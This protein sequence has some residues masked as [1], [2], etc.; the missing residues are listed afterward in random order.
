MDMEQPVRPLDLEKMKRLIETSRFEREASVWIKNGKVLNVYTGELVQANVVISDDRIAYVGDKEPMTGAET[1]IIDAG[2]QVL[3][4]GYIE[5]HAHPYQIYNFRTLGE[6]ALTRGTTTLVIDNLSFYLLLDRE[7]LLELVRESQ[8]FPVKYFWWMSLDPHNSLPEMMKKYTPDQLEP[9]L[10]ERAFIQGGELTSWPLLL[11]GVEP[12]LSSVHLMRSRGKRIEGHLPGASA[13]TLN[14]AAAGGVTACHES[15]TSE[16]VLRRLRLGYYATLRHSSIRPDVPHLVK[17]LVEAGMASSS[18]LMLTTD[19]TTPP[20]LDKGF[21]DHAL[22]LAMEAGMEPIDAYRMATLNIATYY[23]LDHELGGIAPGR[24][25]D[26]CFLEDVRNP[27]PLKVMSDGRVTVENGRRL[28]SFPEVDWTFLNGEEGSGTEKRRWEAR[29]DW[30]V[31]R[32]SPE[33][34]AVSGETVRCEFPVMKMLNAVITK[35]EDRSFEV[36]DER[37]VLS[38]QDREQGY[39]YLSLLDLEGRWVSNG[40]VKGFV[41]Q[42]EALCSTFSAFPGY[43]VAGWNPKSMAEAVN[44]ARSHGGG[45][46]MMEKGEVLYELPL[47]LTHMMSPLPMEKLIP[48]TQEFV[49]LMKERGYVHEDPLYSLLF[50]VALHLPDLRLSHQGLFSVKRGRVLWPARRLD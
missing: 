29:A 26:I 31:P 35:Q 20:F 1:E 16:E 25:A 45:I 33:A 37:V 9:L 5:P 21:T 47:P 10:E 17:G 23:G 8:R 30:F 2:G 40:I 22:R 7:R 39:L 34:A 32:V 48:K 4:P 13:E 49:G 43:V 42:V 38:E 24:V 18:R 27:T 19:G 36:R 50:S 44:R 41:Q 3:V 28:V 46:V 11:K 15:I 6:Y 14:A 12:V